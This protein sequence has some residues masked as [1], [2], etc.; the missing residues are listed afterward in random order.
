MNDGLLSSIFD[1]RSVPAYRAFARSHLPAPAKF[2]QLLL[3]SIPAFIKAEKRYIVVGSVS[4]TDNHGEFAGNVSLLENK[5]FMFFSN[6]GGK[7][8]LT[9]SE[10]LAREKGEVVK[11]TANP[12]HIALMEKEFATMSRIPPGPDRSSCLPRIGKRLVVNNRLFF[13]EEYIRGKC[14]REV[15][16]GLSRR[17]DVAGICIYLDRLDEWFSQYCSSINGEP[18]S[19]SSCYEHLFSSFAELYGSHDVARAVLEQARSTLAALTDSHRGIMTIIAHNDLWPGNFVVDGDRLVA[20]DWERAAEGRAPLFDYY[21]M[22]ISTVLEYHANRLGAADYSQAF[23]RFLAG[24]DMVSDH[25][26]DRLALFLDRLSLGRTLHHFFLLLFLM[27]WSVQGYRA[28]G[29]ETDMDRL[30]FGELVAFASDA[31]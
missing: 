26:R 3:S 13:P 18:R 5:D 1:A 12:D 17:D 27:E 30:A 7:L 4:V 11:T 25:A 8:L 20:I 21:W 22:I 28:L 9:S 16:H 23:R 15:L 10:A 31:S 14:L 19:L 6:A 24:N 2:R 29:R